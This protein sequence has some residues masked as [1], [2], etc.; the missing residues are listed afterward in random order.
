MRA[1]YNPDSRVGYDELFEA[2]RS[3]PVLVLDDLG[4]HSSTPWAQEKLFQLINHRYN[5]RIPTVITM[6]IESEEIDSRLW[7][8]INDMHLTERVTIQAEDSRTNELPP[9]PRPQTRRPRTR[10]SYTP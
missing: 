10:E 2:I 6:N 1:T 8:R 9:A 3:A 4:A 5:R 7:S